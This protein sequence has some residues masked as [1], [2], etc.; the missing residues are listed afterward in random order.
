M[1][2]F[3]PSDPWKILLTKLP[4]DASQV[5]LL[6]EAAENAEKN[7][8][9]RAYELIASSIQRWRNLQADS[10]GEGQK[11][12]TS[13]TRFRY[14]PKKLYQSVICEA[15]SIL[16]SSGLTG[17]LAD[18]EE[19]VESRDNYVDEVGPL[20]PILDPRISGANSRNTMCFL[21]HDSTDELVGLIA[22]RLFKLGDSSLYDAMIR[23]EHNLDDKGDMLSENVYFD[24]SKRSVE[25][26]SELTDSVAI[27]GGAWLQQM[28]HGEKVEWGILRALYASVLCCWGVH[29]V[30]SFLRV[31]DS[32][33]TSAADKTSSPSRATVTVRVPDFKETNTE[34]CNVMVTQLIR[35]FQ[36]DEATDVTRSWLRHPDTKS[37][38]ILIY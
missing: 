29:H 20:L 26:M 34:F 35:E 6:A 10:D 28:H 22:A 38:E 4:L 24:F 11:S 23:D 21:F 36:L 8:A 5:R 16:S 31:N 14:E 37:S 3:K 12:I 19:F 17:R 1:P 15:D 13:A 9:L 33:E 2:K 30:G 27:A 25:V 32:A 18:L 7:V